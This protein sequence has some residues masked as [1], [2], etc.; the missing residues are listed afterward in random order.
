M[1]EPG[2][3]KEHIEYDHIDM[4]YKAMLRRQKT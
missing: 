1:G 4:R 2:S 3:V